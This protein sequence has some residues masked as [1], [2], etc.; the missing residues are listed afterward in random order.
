MTGGT[1]IGLKKGQEDYKKAST[2]KQNF[3][4]T[5]NV[6]TMLSCSVKPFFKYTFLSIKY[7]NDGISIPLKDEKIL[8]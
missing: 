1:V 8:Y 6:E 4:P 2:C 7:R 5:I 3:E